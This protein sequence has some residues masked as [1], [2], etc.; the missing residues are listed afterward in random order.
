[1]I[2]WGQDTSGTTSNRTIYLPTSFFNTS[3]V[4]IP[5]IFGN[6]TSIEYAIYSSALISKNTSSFVAANRFFNESYG[7][8]GLA[9]SWFAIGRWK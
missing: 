3:Y 5:A 8:S 1:M 9:M 6:G 4:V 7:Y 2:Q